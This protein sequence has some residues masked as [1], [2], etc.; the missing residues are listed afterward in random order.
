MSDSMP[1]APRSNDAYGAP[2]GTAAA[3]RFNP[4]AIVSL[5][6]G[7]VG[8]FIGLFGIVGAVALVLG[9]VARSQIARTGQRGRG[10]AL[11]GIIL[12]A[13]ALVFTIVGLIVGYTH[14][15]M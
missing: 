3:G 1:P 15:V 2:G 9:L 13:I 4:L 5:I 10:M 7:I 8:F 12:G 11:A 14:G 6:L